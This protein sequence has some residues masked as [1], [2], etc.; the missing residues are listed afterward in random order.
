MCVTSIA[1]AELA[2]VAYNTFIGLKIAFANS[3]MEICE[4]TAADVDDVSDVLSHATERLLSPMYLRGGMG[5]GGACHPRDNLALSWLA[6]RLGLSYDI[7]EN[8]MMAREAQTEHLADIVQHYSDLTGLDAFLLGTTYKAGVPLQDG[9]P[10]LLLRSI[11]DLR[12]PGRVR[13][14]DPTDNAQPPVEGDDPH[15]FV[16]CVPGLPIPDAPGSV[17]IDPWGS[18]PD[19]AGMTV[20]RLGRKG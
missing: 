11:L 15:V 9:S 13:S 19:M 5:D 17:V 7:F 14:W 4:H 8:A 20:V 16:M 10:A 2:K 3:L 1:S 12:I 6:Q 18:T